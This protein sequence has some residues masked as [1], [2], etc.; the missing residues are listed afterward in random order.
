MP[1]RG[2]LIRVGR[3]DDAQ[4]RHGAQRPEVLDWLMGRAVLAEADRV[5]GPDEDARQLH[6][7]CEPDGPTHV[8]AEDHERSAE[9][10]GESVDR[11]AVED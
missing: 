1:C 9:G 5:M 3:P 6:E 2:G 7:G 10:T 11:N 8:V 4:A